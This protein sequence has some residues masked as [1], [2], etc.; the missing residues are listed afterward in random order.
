MIR[1]ATRKD[2]E[3]IFDIEQTMFNESVYFKL[4]LREIKR[5]LNKSSTYFYV[6]CNNE[7]IAVGYALGIVVNKKAIWFNSLAVL[8]EYQNTF[9]AKA[10]F[11]KIESSCYEMNLST[12]ILEIRKDNK[13]LLRRYSSIG[14]KIWKEIENYY[15][16][17]CSAIRMIK[18]TG[19]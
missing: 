17:G 4:S 9:A 10:L 15:P 7:N 1:R 2:A 5:L 13:A 8:K 19:E 3:A 11:D 16:D 6:F 12:V 14:Y 18:K